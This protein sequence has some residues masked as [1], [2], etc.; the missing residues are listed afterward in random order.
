MTVT[1]RV[2]HGSKHG[3]SIGYPTVNL[4]VTDAVRAAFK[5]YGVYAVC[6]M[7]RG[8]AYCGALFWGVRS[9]FIEMD[10]VCEISLLD[11][12][13]DVYGE[14]VSVEVIQ[15]IRPAVTVVD[16]DELKQLIKKDIQDAQKAYDLFR[17]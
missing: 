1:S 9:L 10:P 15:R 16:K 3:R 13:G 6:A 5:E 14:Q 11:F 17:S 4:A 7:V 12:S 8:E 2:V